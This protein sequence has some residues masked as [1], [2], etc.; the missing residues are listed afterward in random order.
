MVDAPRHSAVIA[1]IARGVEKT[2]SRQG[3]HAVAGREV[4]A[5]AIGCDRGPM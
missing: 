4:L 3:D 1:Q 5:P 2:A